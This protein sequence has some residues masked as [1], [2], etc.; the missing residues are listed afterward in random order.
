METVILP[1]LSQYPLRVCLF[2]AVKNAAF[3]R[4]QLLEGNQEFEYAFLDASVLLS[5][6]H[7]LAACF[8]AIYDWLNDR[9]KSRNVHSE[10]VFSLSPNNNVSIH[11][12][13]KYTTSIFGSS[14]CSPRAF[15]QA[16]HLTL[17][18]IAES[19]RRFGISDDSENILAIKVGD[20]A[21][22][23]EAH[24]KQ[25]VEGK[26]VAFSDEVLAELRDPGRIRK[27][28]RVDLSQK[29]D[30]GTGTKGAEAFVLGSMALK[31]S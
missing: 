16:L 7:V 8:R 11:V 10:I 9:L 14:T 31:G 24:L 2:T 4:R 19:F 25:H 30:A 17:H 5:R 22:Q 23:V 6:S 13:S 27:M 29:G 3:L 28:Y 18:K 12:I 15:R 1:H 20:D 21:S 26:P